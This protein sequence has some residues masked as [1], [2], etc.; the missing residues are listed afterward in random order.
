VKVGYILGTFP[1]LTE[2]FVLR[3]IGALRRR[4]VD[5]TV[6]AVRRASLAQPGSD[7]GAL[8]QAVHCTY[9][10]PDG[11]LRHAWANLIC[12]LARP[13][14]YIRGLIL[15]V[16]QSSRLSPREAA[17]LLSHYFV[18]VG[19][20]RDVQ[21]LGLTHVHSHFTSAA[22]IGLAIHLVGDTS[23]S[24]TAHA[25]NDLFV[26]PLLLPE[27]AAAAKFVVAVCDYSRHYLDAVTGYRY[28]G[29]I[30]RI[31]N[32]IDPDEQTRQVRTM[33]RASNMQLPRAVVRIVSVGT[34]VPPKGFGTLIQVCARLRDNGQ[35]LSCRIVGEGPERRTLEWLIAA[36]NLKGSVE[37]VGALPLEQV[38]A[39]LREAD[40]FALL[41]E[42]G[43]SGYRDGF[44]TVILEAMAAGLPVLSTRLSGIPEMVLDGV[45]GTLVPERD[46]NAATQA[47]QSLLQSAELRLGMGTAG[48]ARVRQHFDLK[49]AADELAVLFGSVRPGSGETP[50]LSGVDRSL[51][52]PVG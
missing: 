25:S 24:F 13:Q 41:A 45:T 52:S 9:S 1:A 39:E 2:T 21:R 43:P 31:Y 26:R 4:G 47:L 17:Q 37:L 18:G 48:Q 23:F 3:E 42:I 14:R 28:S 40:V 11:L 22:N 33:P 38:Y 27:K 34:L 32:G 7:V 35:V 29:K 44:P 49:K 46:V 20:A 51:V 15:F 19:F 8:T 16:R 6:L 50:L 30:R 5:V 12:F 10:R 36:N